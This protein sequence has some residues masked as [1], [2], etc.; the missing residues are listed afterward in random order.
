MGTLASV[1]GTVL[2]AF[3]A[4]ALFVG[5]GAVFLSGF[6]PADM[7]SEAVAGRFGSLLVWTATA[8]TGLVG[9]LAVLVASQALDWAVAIVAAGSAFLLAPFLVQPV[10]DHL[11]DT[12]AGLAIFTAAGCLV[13]LALFLEKLP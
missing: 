13:L 8:I 11:R 7:R 12:K 2:A 5:A 6:F 4:A 1:D 10:P 9:A 3:S